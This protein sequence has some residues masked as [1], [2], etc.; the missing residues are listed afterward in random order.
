MLG[1]KRT[2]KTEEREKKERGI[3]EFSLHFIWRKMHF[4][5]GTLSLLSA[6]SLSFFS[7]LALRSPYFQFCYLSFFKALMVRA[8]HFCCNQRTQILHFPVEP[9]SFFLSFLCLSFYLSFS[10]SPFFCSRR[11]TK[12]RLLYACAEPIVTPR[13]TEICS[14]QPFSFFA[15]S[16]TYC[17]G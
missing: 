17:R 8:S 10:L 4:L 13:R 5:A 6:H 2:E 12:T 1:K 7:P 15:H 9:L 14:K 11:C 16:T 3:R